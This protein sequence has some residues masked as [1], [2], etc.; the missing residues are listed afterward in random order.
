[1]PERTTVGAGQRSAGGV[2]RRALVGAGEVAGEPQMVAASTMPTMTASTAIMRGSPS[3]EAISSLP[4][5]SSAKVA[6]GRRRRQWP[7]DTG[8]DR[9]DVEA[10]VGSAEGVLAGPDPGD[11]DADESRDS[12]DGRDDEQARPYSPK[13]TEPRISAATSITAYDS[14]R[15]AAMPAQSPTLSPTLSAM[16]AALRGRPRG[17]R[18]RPCRPG[19][20]RRPRPW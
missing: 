11:E 17:C 18:P 10:A 15:S 12:P 6:G 20:R 19:R 1:M 14:N 16:V 5:S 3:K 2:L 4:V 9:G 13:A 8:D 7:K